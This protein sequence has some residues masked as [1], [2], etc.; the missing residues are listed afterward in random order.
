L[1]R[2]PGGCGVDDRNVNATASVH[3]AVAFTI[4]AVRRTAPDAARVRLLSGPGALAH[5]AVDG[6]LLVV[7]LVVGVV[8]DDEVVVD[9]SLDDVVPFALELPS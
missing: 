1:I 6:G 9:G 8:V 4:T 5:G 2:T 7:V 3:R